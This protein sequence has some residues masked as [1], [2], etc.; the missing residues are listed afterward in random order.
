MWAAGYRIMSGLCLADGFWYLPPWVIGLGRNHFEQVVANPDALANIPQ[1]RRAAST[2]DHWTDDD[3]PCWE[4]LNYVSR[5][6]YDRATGEVEGIINALDE[7]DHVHPED[8]APTR[9]REPPPA[10]TRAWAL[11]GNGR[12]GR[13]IGATSL[14]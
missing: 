10:P 13:L 8:P 1:V 5:G 14:K 9:Y 11:S 7:L 3:W 2:M 4:A 12:G 6:A